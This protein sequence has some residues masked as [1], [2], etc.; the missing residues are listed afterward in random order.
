MDSSS[1]MWG[2]VGVDKQKVSPKITPQK[3]GKRNQPLKVHLEKKILCEFT[4]RRFRDK[5]I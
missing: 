2:T 1:I 5:Y 3:G 4:P